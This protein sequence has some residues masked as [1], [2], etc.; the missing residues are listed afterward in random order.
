SS[1]NQKI[2]DYWGY[3]DEQT[4]VTAILDPQTKLTLFASGIPTSNAISTITA[5]LRSYHV[6]TS[7]SCN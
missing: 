2:D 4:L 1:I 5:L 3:I 7:G 6:M